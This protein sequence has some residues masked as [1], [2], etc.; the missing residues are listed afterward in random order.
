MGL[1]ACIRGSLNEFETTPELLLQ[2]SAL[3]MF[4]FSYELSILYMWLSAFVDP[5][6]CR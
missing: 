3:K 6:L 2:V 5:I 1:A 4:L